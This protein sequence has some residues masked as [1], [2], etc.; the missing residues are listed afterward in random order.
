[1]WDLPGLGLKLVS[2]ALAGR[3]I[4]TAPPG[5]PCTIVSWLLLPC[6]CIPSLPWLATRWTCPLELRERHGGWS[7]FPTNKKR[8][9]QKGFCAQEPHRVLLGFT[10][11]LEP[12][13]ANVRDCTGLWLEGCWYCNCRPTVLGEEMADAEFLKDSWPFWHPSL[14]GQGDLLS[15]NPQHTVTATTEGLHTGHDSIVSNWSHGSAGLGGISCSVMHDKS[16]WLT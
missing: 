16:L 12:Q 7:P 2:P 5:K 10:T 1:M 11:S 9:T 15:L 6:L 14:Q 3:F 4:T 13:R 8:G